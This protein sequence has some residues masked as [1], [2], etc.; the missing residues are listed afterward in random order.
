MPVSVPE[1]ESPRTTALSRRVSR[2]LRPLLSRDPFASFEQEM[3]DL[4]SRFQADWSGDLAAAVA[5]PPVDVSETDDSLEVRL[6]VPGLKP[7]E[8]DIEITG[9]TL[10]VSGEHK[11]EKEEKGKT[12]H[13][14]ER[15]SAAFARAVSLPAPVKE[16]QV[17]AACKDGV[18]TITLP[19]TEAAKTRKIAVKGNGQ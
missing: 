14:L 18:L 8:I 6:D 12:W 11:E 1:Q 4:L 16:G 13:R 17:N 9:N 15:R 2:A 10:R 19:K 5:I 7:E 3:D